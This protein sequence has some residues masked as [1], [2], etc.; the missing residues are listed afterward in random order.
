MVGAIVFLARLV[1]GL[2]A[3]FAVWFV[4][5][6][7]HDRNT[8][9]IVSTIGLMYAFIFMI[10]RRLQNIGL[11][12]FSFFGRTASYVGVAPYDQVPKDEAGLGATSRHLY[13]NVVFA[14][15]IE[16]LCLFRLFSSLTGRW[17]HLLSDPIEDLLH[18]VNF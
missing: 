3:L 12:I 5:D 6:N 10:S 18:S 1:A 17:W 9:I 14:V 4:L 13:L 8:E 7:I 2:L 11:T 15:L 16:I